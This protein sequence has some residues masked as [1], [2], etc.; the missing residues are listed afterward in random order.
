MKEYN[1]TNANYI[2][3]DDELVYISQIEHN[4]KIK[5][6]SSAIVFGKVSTDE[7]IVA[8][9]SLTCFGNIQ[10]IEVLVQQDLICYKDIE[11]EVLEVGGSLKCY[12]HISAKEIYVK[13]EAILNSAYVVSGEIQKDIMLEG[14][15]EVDNLLTIS[16]GVICK[17]GAVGIGSIKCDYLY[18]ND[19]LEINV[20]GEVIDKKRIEDEQKNCFVIPNINAIEELPEDNEV[21]KALSVRKK[22]L[23]TLQYE[24]LRVSHEAEIGEIKSVLRKLVEMDNSFK[25]DYLLISFVNKIEEVKRIEMITDFLELVKYEK[26]CP[27]Y[28]REFDTC[29]YLFNQYLEKQR[30]NIEFMT[31]ENINSHREFVYALTLLESVK[32]ELSDR[33][34]EMILDKIYGHIGIKYKLISRAFK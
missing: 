28:L 22:I 2:T 11:C 8:N 18:A 29:A 31:C 32:D 25:G 27:E 12:G 3:S 21:H 7:D 33:E 30:S 10:G 9:Y 17:E 23:T 15:L 14:T 34:Y 4:K 13:G 1:Y 6:D 26:K 19:Y 5:F 20:D 16:G 24:I